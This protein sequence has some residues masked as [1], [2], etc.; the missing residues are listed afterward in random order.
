METF[1][2][3]IVRGA[4]AGEKKGEYVP[5]HQDSVKD[6]AIVKLAH[7]EKFGVRVI[8][9][10]ATRCRLT[11]QCDGNDKQ[12]AGKWILNAREEATLYRKASE[13]K[14]FVCVRQDSAESTTSGADPKNPQNGFIDL[15]F[16]P[17]LPILRDHHINS[18]SSRG[19]LGSGADENLSDF[20]YRGRG[21]DR[22]R[23]QERS[24]GGEESFTR[25]TKGMRRESKV[26]ETAESKAKES[27]AHVG[28]GGETGQRFDTVADITREDKDRIRRVHFQIVC[29]G[30][31]DSPPAAASSSSSRS[32]ITAA[33]PL[34]VHAV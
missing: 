3:Y 5:F 15:I 22:D 26:V 25:A 17:E 1:G 2:A 8:N 23:E 21:G 30:L 18:I 29:I 6:R 31:V 10:F 34:Y 14:A 20:Q 32:V 16:T 13:D 4:T 11:I 28:Y 7:L 33:N 12:P 9:P 27:K 19:M 24:R